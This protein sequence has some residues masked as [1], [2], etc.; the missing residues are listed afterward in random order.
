MEV[1]SKM[2]EISAP[3]AFEDIVLQKTDTTLAVLKS[4]DDD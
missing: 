2:A 4:R 1:V 3:E